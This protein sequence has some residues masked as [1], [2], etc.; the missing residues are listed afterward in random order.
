MQQKPNTNLRDL[1]KSR[2]AEKQKSRK[3]E[4]QKSRKTETRKPISHLV[5]EWDD[6]CLSPQD[7]TKGVA[8]A[9]NM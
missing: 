5:L 9:S 1:L 6:A 2:K 3:A 4:K 8:T 7:N